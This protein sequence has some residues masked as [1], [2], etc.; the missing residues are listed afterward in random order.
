M[1]KKLSKKELVKL[2]I[3][4]YGY[5][6]EDLK[7]ENGKIYTNAKLEEMVEQEDKDLKEAE[8][9][10]EIE[11]TVVVE[12]KAFKFKDD[13]LIVVMNGLS[14]TLV[15]RSDMTGRVW[16]MTDFGQ[17]TK[18][19]Y[20][21]LLNIRNRSPKVFKDGWLIVL[22]PHIQDEFELTEIYKNIVTPQ[23]VEE[24]I[25]KSPEEIEVF[26][27]NMPK[28]AKQAFIEKAKEMY[29]NGK[30]DS[31]KKINTIQQLFGFSLED[32]APLEDVIKIKND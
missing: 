11:K 14:G 5:D 28:G 18:I 21:E 31:V 4:E 32:N 7:D 3:E 1:V 25:S 19:P 6:K 2:L 10:K 22:N 23:N 15:H 30:L 13:D 20:G 24:I 26:V 16:R 8:E 9:R 17:T 29:T 27:K 12:T